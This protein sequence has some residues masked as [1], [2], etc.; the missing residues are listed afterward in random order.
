MTKV[1]FVQTFFSIFDS[2]HGTVTPH[3]HAFLL[4]LLERAFE[5]EGHVTDEQLEGIIMGVEDDDGASV[6]EELSNEFPL[7]NALAL[8][9]IEFSERGITEEFEEIWTTGSVQ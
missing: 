7:L 2:E 3:D 8:F 4:P 9:G 1:E 5:R 6:P